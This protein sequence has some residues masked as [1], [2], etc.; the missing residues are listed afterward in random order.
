MGIELL[1]IGK[2]VLN[3]LHMAQGVIQCTEGNSTMCFNITTTFNQLCFQSKWFVMFI[4]VMIFI[5]I[6]DLL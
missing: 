3:W 4:V 6:P 2:L 5:K 1:A